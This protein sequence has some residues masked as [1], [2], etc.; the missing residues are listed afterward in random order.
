MFRNNH[1][2]ETTIAPPRPQPTQQDQSRLASVVLSVDWEAVED[3]L[4]VGRRG[5]GLSEP[6]QVRSPNMAGALRPSLVSQSHTASSNRVLE[7]FPTTTSKGGDVTEQDQPENQPEAPEDEEL[8]RARHRH[9]GTKLRSRGL[10]VGEVDKPLDEPTE[11][12]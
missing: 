12:D 6:D 11:E 1:L 2:T 7:S 9:L 3:R 4:R 10:I 8:L 5:P